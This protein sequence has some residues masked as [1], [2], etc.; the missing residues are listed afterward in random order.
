MTKKFYLIFIFLLIFLLT[1]IFFLPKIFSTKVGTKFLLKK[2]EK[3][4]LAKI[5]VNSFNLSW[6]GPQIIQKL[7]Y[8]DENM[9]LQ[10]KSIKS[11]ISLISLYKTL[12]S[13]DELK[14]FANTDISDLD[15]TLHYPTLPKASIY[16]VF[17]SIKADENKISSIKVTGKTKEAQVSGD[18]EA[19]FD[20]I[21]SKIEAKI[22]GYNIPT[23][24]I[25]RLLFHNKKK[26]QNILV[27]ILG[28]S[29][30]INVS[31]SLDNFNGPI[32]IDLNSSYTKAKLNL[33]YAKNIISLKEDAKITIDLPGINPTILKK[34][35]Y[36]KTISPTVITISSKDFSLPIRPFTLDKLRINQINLDL[37]KLQLSNTSFIKKIT[38]F[39][40]IQ[41]SDLVTVWFTNVN[42]RVENNNLF[43]DR[44]DFLID[45]ELHLC[46]FGK[47]DLFDHKIKFNV[48]IPSDTLANVFNIKN[49]PDDY[50]MK[51]P[52]SGTIENPK[53]DAKAAGAKILAL[54][55]LQTAKGIG[56][57]ISSVLTKIKKDDDIP[58]ARK[59]FPW[60]GKVLKKNVIQPV[61][62]NKIDE[63]FE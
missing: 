25:D 4:I 35:N 36:V 24:G 13:K 57:I 37:N 40:K 3:K 45:N 9:D 58:K 60:E 59:P 28:P 12:K 42:L 31:S 43:C 10:V 32:N 38:K 5:D 39:A 50:V 27:Q 51:I 18:I 30:N 34:I 55:T 21:G 62:A 22:K 19:K 7:S 17:A 54:S 44:V 41:A 20:F 56:S 1:T 33:F 15:I 61:D 46:A 26:Y 49:L 11:N 2:I 14:F 52:I 63:L 16:N 47:V 48:G 53:I 23:I 8:S 29:L 6:S